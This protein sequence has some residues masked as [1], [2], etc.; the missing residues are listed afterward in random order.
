MQRVIVRKEDIVE[1]FAY[2][3]HAQRTHG[4]DGQRVQAHHLQLIPGTPPTSAPKVQLTRAI[5]QP[6]APLMAKV[7][8]LG[9]D[10]SLVGATK[11]SADLQQGAAIQQVDEDAIA[12]HG[13]RGDRRTTRRQLQGELK[14]SENN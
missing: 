10:V 13:R 9:V 11:A 14:G 2:V 12:G 4:L 5:A 3:E 7:L 8:V 6:G 1:A